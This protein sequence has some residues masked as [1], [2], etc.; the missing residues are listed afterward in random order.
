VAANTTGGVTGKMI[1]PQSIAVACAATGLVGKESELFRFTVKH[2]LLFA[3][4]VGVITMLQAY[5][6]T[7]MI[8]GDDEPLPPAPSGRRSGHQ[9]F[10]AS[11]GRNALP[12][13]SGA[14]RYVAGV[15]LSLIGR[16][17]LVAAR[18]LHHHLAMRGVRMRQ[19]IGHRQH[20]RARHARIGQFVGQRLAVPHRQLRFQRALQHCARLTERAPAV[21]KRSSSASSGTPRYRTGCGTAGRCPRPGRSDR[22][23]WPRCRT[24]RCSDARCRAARRLAAHEPVGGVRMQ[25][26]QAR[27]IKRR[28]H[29]LAAPAALALLQCQQHAQAALRPVTMSTTGKP[30]RS[31]SAS[32]L[33][34]MMPAI[35]WIAAS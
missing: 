31:G 3:F 10:A 19:R 6:L 8:R 26:R 33:M 5:W 23:P 9:S 28:F 12:S 11:R 2:S 32:P 13:V 14:Y 34:L 1:S 15:R 7:G 30:T 27:V 17:A 24:D 4:I 18:H 22:L 25:Q 21:A 29:E 16:P 35:A 20:R